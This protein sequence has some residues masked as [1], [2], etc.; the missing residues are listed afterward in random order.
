MN[1]SG[2]SGNRSD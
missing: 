1:F 2:H